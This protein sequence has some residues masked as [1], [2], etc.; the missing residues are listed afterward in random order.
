MSADLLHA[1]RE[2]GLTEFGSVIEGAFVRRALNMT[3]PDV[4]TREDFN[5]VALAEL[6]AIGYVRHHLL[7]EGKYITAE[8]ENYRILLPSE[9]AQQV[10]AYL[11]AANRKRRMGLRLLR[12]T[13]PG[14]ATF[15]SQLEARLAMRDTERRRTGA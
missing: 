12:S 15:P 5:R 3:M 1:L 4:G 2:A 13:P 7:N 11:D 9:N 10:E 14:M 8:R 6:A